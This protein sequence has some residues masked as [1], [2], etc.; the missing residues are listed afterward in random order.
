MNNKIKYFGCTALLIVFAACSNL[1]E[2]APVSQLETQYLFTTAD[3][4]KAAIAG[5]Y[6]S[7]QLPGVYG[8]CQGLLSTDETFAGSKVPL[9]G[10]NT[11]NFT[12]DNIEVVLP[13]WRDHYA[14]INRANLSISNIPK[15]AD[16]VMA[17]NERNTLV[18]EAKF[19]RALLY[20]NLIRY[21]G[22]VP[23][24]N[25]ETVSLNNLDIPRTP[26]AVIN[27]SIIE[28]LKYGVKNLKPKAPG[29]AGRATIDAARTLLASVYLTRGSMAKRDGTGDGRVDFEWAA[30][31]AK[32]VMDSGRYSLCDY[33]PDA[34][35]VDNKNNNEIIFDVQFKSPGFGEGNS[36]GIN[37]GIP[38]DASGIT[39]LLAGGAQAS[40]RANAYH[41]YYYAAADSVR[42]QWT[43][44]RIR[45]ESSTGRFQRLIASNTKEPVSAAK[46]R[47]Y[48]VRDPNFFLMID[49]DYNVN[50]PVFRYAEVLLI[51]A[52][53]L[54]ETNVLTQTVIDESL[55][56]LR[57]RA[58]NVNAGGV[59]ADVLPRSLTLNKSIGLADLTVSTQAA[60]RDYIFEERSR[61]LSQEGKRWFD[62]VRWGKLKSTLSGLIAKMILKSNE[63]LPKWYWPFDTPSVSDELHKI[64][65]M[66]EPIPLRKNGS[67]NPNAFKNYWNGNSG[68]TVE[69]NS[70]IANLDEKKHNLFPI[71]NSEILANPLIGANNPEY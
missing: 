33:F 24:K 10:I 36:I 21:Y 63:T 30:Q 54:N 2:E 57:R 18:A 4:A 39:N 59:H 3:N 7:L 66:S 28:D 64:E 32:D 71:P 25:T 55:N 69:W 56:K 37:M 70:I 49:G 67:V 5:V 53:A 12:A 14:G 6:S 20:F 31:Y 27:D 35:I 19:I 1:L 65:A 62:L 13:M 17:V 29:L 40:I 52:E 16:A 60:F 23:Y 46:F 47:H 11:Y 15:I 42:L 45:I 22:A 43:D 48:P 44:A 9:G 8:R 38:S 61:E 34:F 51:Y 26:V 68:Q 50:W 41:P 58:R